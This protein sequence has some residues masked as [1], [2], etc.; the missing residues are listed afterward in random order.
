MN[1]SNQ[2][3][4]EIVCTTCQTTLQSIQSGEK[5]GCPECYKIF[6]EFIIN[7][8]S[9]S[10]KLP[11]EVAK[12]TD[13][14]HMGK[15]PQEVQKETPLPHRIEMLNSALCEAV[16]LENYEKAAGLRDQIQTLMEKQNQ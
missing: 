12:K 1:P 13:A 6:K 9:D 8:L 2:F 7:M 4:D 5:L 15:V 16:A 3:Q 14:M 11:F 10:D